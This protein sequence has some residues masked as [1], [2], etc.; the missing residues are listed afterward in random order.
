MLDPHTTTV[1][2]MAA[3]ICTLIAALL[4]ALDER[5]R[6]CRAVREY[7]AA[8][9]FAALQCGAVARRFLSGWQDGTLHAANP[10]LD[11]EW[12]DYRRRYL[13]DDREDRIWS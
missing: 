3:I 2:A 10:A 7:H 8:M 1:L 4:L 6:Q 5:A 13:S 9:T 12:Q 11:A